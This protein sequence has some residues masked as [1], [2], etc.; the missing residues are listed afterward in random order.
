MEIPKFPSKNLKASQIN[1]TAGGLAP[2]SVSLKH[3]MTVAGKTFFRVCFR[4]WPHRLRL[5]DVLSVLVRAVGSYGI[6]G[7]QIRSDFKQ[8]EPT[9]DLFCCC[10]LNSRF[11]FRTR[12]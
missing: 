5:D 9:G 6:T 7:L 12:S 8:K 2:S 11:F 1:V 10:D 3:W 4:W